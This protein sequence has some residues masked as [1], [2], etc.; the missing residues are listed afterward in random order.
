[1]RSFGRRWGAAAT[2]LEQST[3]AE[4]SQPES[5][6]CLQRDGVAFGA[7]TDVLLVLWRGD[8]PGL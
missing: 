1:M 2:D 7:R 5:S 4:E 6:R 8:A 3:E